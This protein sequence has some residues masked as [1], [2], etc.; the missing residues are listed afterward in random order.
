MLHFELTCF[1]KM[2]PSFSIPHLYPMIHHCHAQGLGLYLAFHNLNPNALSSQ[3]RT[4][5]KK[6]GAPAL[7][8]LW[9]GDLSSEKEMWES[10]TNKTMPPRK[11]V[12]KEG[13]PHPPLRTLSVCAWDAFRLLRTSGV[14]FYLSILLLAIGPSVPFAMGNYCACAES[15]SAKI[16][17]VEIR[18]EEGPSVPWDVPW[19]S[20]PTRVLTKWLLSLLDLLT[21]H[22]FKW[23]GWRKEPRSHMTEAWQ[24][25]FEGQG[26]QHNHFRWERKWNSSQDLV[27]LM[28]LSILKWIWLC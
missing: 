3:R 9:P 27:D 17:G 18:V 24:K 11:E 26:T 6:N 22:I 28:V 19:S 20:D 21:Q 5:S 23:N 25:A 4:D 2:A 12:P 13:C 15:R 14:P 10:F 1:K 16:N 8:H 7:Q